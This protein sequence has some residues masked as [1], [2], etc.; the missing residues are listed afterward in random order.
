MAEGEQDP[1]PGARPE[2]GEP[3]DRR[4]VVGVEAV[5]QPERADQAEVHEHGVGRWASW[6]GI[7]RWYP[8]DDSIATKIQ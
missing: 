6:T 1:V 5:A 2:P 8:I 7:P 3:V 4:E